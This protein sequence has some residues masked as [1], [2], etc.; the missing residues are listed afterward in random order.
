MISPLYWVSALTYAIVLTAILYRD[1]SPE[2][3]PSREERAFTQLIQCVLFFCLQDAL[4]GLCGGPGVSHAAFFAASTLFHIST[5]V[6]AFFWLR[7]VLAYLGDRVKHTGYYLAI[8]GGIIC[9][10]LGLLTAN[11]FYPTIF[12]IDEAGRY[13]TAFLRP[14]AFWDQY[15]V[16]LAMSI[17]TLSV[18]LREA[19]Q[20]RR[21][22]MAVFYFTL[23]PVLTGVFQLMYPEAPF[24]SLGYFL[25]CFMIHMF[26]VSRDRT[27][28][29]QMRSQM[30]LAAQI[31]INRTDE[32]TGM[33]NRHAY[34]LDM[35]ELPLNSEGKHLCC[36]SVDVNGLKDVNDALGHAA[37]DELLR[38]CA[39]CIRRSFGEKGKVYRIGGDEF[40]VTLMADEDMLH[41]CMEQFR[42]CLTEWRGE[43][44]KRMSAAIG[45]ASGA[46]FPDCD[47]RELSQIADDRMYKDKA[48]YYFTSG[49]ERRSEQS[50]YAALCATYAKILKVNLT[51]DTYRIVSMEASERDVRKGFRENISEWLRQFGLSGQ[52]HPEDLP[53]Y[54]QQTDMDSL[55]ALFRSGERSTCIFYRRRSGENFQPTMME[56]IIAEDY[57]HD[58]QS[59]YLYVK[60]I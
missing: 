20:I 36:I 35:N 58:N 38:G 31:A 15:V 23:A 29:M 59:L 5:V 32:L 43:Q 50:A 3:S 33:Q 28:L 17:A 52:V 10:Q 6:T 49:I 27:N 56:L 13:C 39:D 21:Q 26:I 7:Y 24:Y 40:A 18:A 34:E 4:W 2:G 51:R 46:E 8:V 45:V 53:R 57:T 9:L 14:L 60:E 47:A 44:V 48:V 30:K 19:G 22:F 42:T 11:F 37:G 55:R 54:L 12:Y 25:G 1:R 16:F 41:L